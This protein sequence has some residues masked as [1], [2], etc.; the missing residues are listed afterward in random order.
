MAAPPMLSFYEAAAKNLRM[1]QLL[2]LL[3]FLLFFALGSAIGNAYGNA[4]YGVALA[5]ILYAILAATAWFSGSSV[6]LSIHGAREAD[7]AEHRRL[8]NVVEEMRIA[9]GLPM[10]RVYLMESEGMNAFA[11]GRRPRE[12][13]VAVTTGLLDGLSRE[14][15]QGVIAHEMAH[16]KSRDTLYYICAAVLVGSIALLADMFLRGTFFGGR[17][18]AGRVGR[19][20]AAFVLLGILFALLAPLSAK[21]LQ[22]SISRQREYHA[23]AEAAWFTRNPLGLA[24][25]LEKIALVGS[26]V[27]GKNRGTQHLFIVNPVRRF[28]ETSTALFSTHPPTALR[29][30]R[31]KAMAGRGGFA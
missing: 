19:G 22:M 3:L 20:N 1:S 29:I 5:L 24:S 27:S 4:G 9:S 13:A 28:T 7:P 31:L 14:E 30:Q 10:P 17:R 25:A 6:V 8:L 2:F 23:D 21:I 16:I 18:Q 12:A 26:D 11:A 15:L